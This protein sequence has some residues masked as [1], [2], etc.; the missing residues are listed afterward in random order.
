VPG[1]DA[2]A[3]ATAG[4]DTGGV[5]ELRDMVF[6]DAKLIPRSRHRVSKT[7]ATI[8]AVMIAFF[9]II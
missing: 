2:T 3:G 7:M 8:I 9:I 5:L 1:A 4:V 6:G